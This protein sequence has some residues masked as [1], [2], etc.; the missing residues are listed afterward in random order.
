MRRPASHIL[1][2]SGA[3]AA[4]PI[5]SNAL[6][7]ASIG[8]GIGMGCPDGSSMMETIGEGSGWEKIREIR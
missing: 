2:Q 4:I 5:G 8:E 6:D 1:F 3:L 7:T